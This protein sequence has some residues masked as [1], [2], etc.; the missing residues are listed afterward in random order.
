MFVTPCPG[1]CYP[2]AYFDGGVPGGLAP[3]VG[4]PTALSL[5]GNLAC[6]SVEGCSFAAFDH[7]QIATCVTPVATWSWGQLKAIYR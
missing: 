1:T 6:G 2:S 7:W 3:Y 5:F 4:T